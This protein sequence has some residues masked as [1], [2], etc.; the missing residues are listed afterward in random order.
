MEKVRNPEFT[1]VLLDNAS[2]AYCRGYQYECA[3][4]WYV[5]AMKDTEAAIRDMVASG[6]RGGNL[7]EAKMDYREKMMKTPLRSLAPVSPRTPEEYRRVMLRFAEIL[8][9]VLP[10]PPEPD[11][12][13]VNATDEI[14]M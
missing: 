1:R 5:P 10:V 7:P 3:A 4:H 6:K 2:C 11:T 13:V 14:L 8:E 12:G 9:K